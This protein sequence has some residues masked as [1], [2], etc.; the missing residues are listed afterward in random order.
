M[1]VAVEAPHSPLHY[2][3]EPWTNETI[4]EGG[5]WGNP[6]NEYYEDRRM[7]ATMILAMDDYV[8]QIVDALRDNYVD[9]ERIWD[10]TYLFFFSD[11][12]GV[13]AH[14]SNYP[15]RG[16]KATNFEGI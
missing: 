15:L 9:G 11:N 8:G 14:A 4:S 13:I 16:A 10:N 12:G 1:T 2:A 6:S 5:P 7:Y 3:P